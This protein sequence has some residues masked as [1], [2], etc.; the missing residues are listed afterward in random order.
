MHTMRLIWHTTSA[1]V[2]AHWLDTKPTVHV[3]VADRHGTPGAS[4]SV[5]ACTA[6]GQHEPSL[7]GQ[8]PHLWGLLR[9]DLSR[10]LSRFLSRDLSR[11]LSLDLSDRYLMVGDTSR[12]RLNLCSQAQLEGVLPCTFEHGDVLT[13]EQLCTC[14]QGIGRQHELCGAQQ[15]HSVPH[16]ACRH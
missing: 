11:D 6:P 14:G 3:L 16:M 7:H 1:Q 12:L 10:L 9:R 13:Q 15:V 8:S 2:S 4:H 5:M